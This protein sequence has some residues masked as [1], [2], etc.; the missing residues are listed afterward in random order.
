MSITNKHLKYILY[1]RQYY[2]LNKL[3]IKK[4]AKDK[5]KNLDYYNKHL[6]YHRDYYHKK[7]YHVDNLANMVITIE[8]NVFIYFN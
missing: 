2:N 5:L 7:K 3:N 4:K 6:K 1:Q 8:R